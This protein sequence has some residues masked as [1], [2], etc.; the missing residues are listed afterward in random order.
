[1]GDALTD[2][3]IG[4]G[5]TRTTAEIRT[6]LADLSDLSAPQNSLPAPLTPLESQ[7][8]P[9]VPQN[10]A[11][12]PEAKPTQ[13][14]ESTMTTDE[15]GEAPETSAAVVVTPES[16]QSDNDASQIA[17]LTPTTDGAI[18]TAGT[19]ENEEAAI[20]PVSQP[21]LV[22][23]VSEVEATTETTDKAADSSQESLAPPSSPQGAAPSRSV[24]DAGVTIDADESSL[25]NITGLIE[26]L[27]TENEVMVEEATPPAASETTSGSVTKASK[28]EQSDAV[29]EGETT[30]QN[31]MV[32]QYAG[33]EGD[34]RNP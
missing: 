7:P 26:V 20:A 6:Y 33:S 10:V 3:V 23:S 34:R 32:V 29:S 5:A 28:D 30:P 1:M 14:P 2:G 25:D 18:A 22:H 11:V 27:P 8:A 17:E 19:S 15:P 9:L 24:E 13:T 31:A 16:A 4:A 12:E 21:L